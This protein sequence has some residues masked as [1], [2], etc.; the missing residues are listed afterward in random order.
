MIFAVRAIADAKGR[1]THAVRSEADI[2]QKGHNPNK[3]RTLQARM[4][5]SRR[6]ASAGMDD[7]AAATS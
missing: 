6:T 4:Y 5:A 3:V 2:K 1:L 7:T